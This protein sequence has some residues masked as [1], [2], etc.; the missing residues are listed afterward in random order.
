MK[1]KSRIPPLNFPLISGTAVEI[2]GKGCLM[3]QLH[4]TRS[5]TIHLKGGKGTSTHQ[6]HFSSAFFLF[7]SE[8]PLLRE[9]Q[10]TEGDTPFIYWVSVLKN[11]QKLKNSETCLSKGIFGM[12]KILPCQSRWLLLGFSFNFEFWSNYR[13]LQRKY[14]QT[15]PLGLVPRSVTGYILCKYNTVSKSGTYIYIQNYVCIG[16]FFR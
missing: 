13:K 10:Y 7:V 8:I 12:F 9:L 1:Q 14:W 4:W 6:L 3:N 5:G 15:D 2:S 16:F 11:R